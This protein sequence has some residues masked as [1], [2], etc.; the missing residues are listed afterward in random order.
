MRSQMRYL[1]PGQN[2]K[3]RVVG[4]EAQVAPPRCRAPANKPI[5]AAEMTRRRT[6]RQTSNRPRLHPRHILK[7]FA[8]RLLISEV[9]MLFHQ[10]V[11]QRFFRRAPNF[12][13]VDGLELI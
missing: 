5:P 13:D 8:H 1:Y 2:Q 3:T 10:A 9:V 4:Q 6:P 7:M 11:E 12:V